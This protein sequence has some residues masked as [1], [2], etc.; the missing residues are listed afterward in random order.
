MV[1]PI[2]IQEFLKLIFE[3]FKCNHYIDPKGNPVKLLKQLT[4]GNT[5]GNH[6]HALDIVVSSPSNVSCNDTLYFL[7][8]IL[9]NISGI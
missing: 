6:G 7:L 3:H 4:Y 8:K 1:N 2:T 9:L 5:M